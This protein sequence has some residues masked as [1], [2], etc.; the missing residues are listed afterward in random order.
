LKEI[1][2]KFFVGRRAMEQASHRRAARLQRLRYAST[3][4]LDVTWIEGSE[5]I[6][7]VSKSATAAKIL[8][9]S[10]S[11][12]LLAAVGKLMGVDC[13]TASCRQ[14]IAIAFAALVGARIVVPA[15]ARPTIVR[16]MGFE[17][18]RRLAPAGLACVKASK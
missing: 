8:E 3:V 7:A 18:A 15:T 12:P 1:S 16:I 2:R 9:R 14:L 11:D 4:L 6:V 13:R 10:K 5:R 17:F